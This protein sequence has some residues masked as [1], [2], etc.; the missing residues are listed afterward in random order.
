MTYS[1]S[2]VS[3]GVAKKRAAMWLMPVAAR[4]HTWWRR[5]ESNSGPKQSPDRCL[6]AQSL[7]NL[8]RALSSDKHRASQ[9]VRS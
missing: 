5:G 3:H 8:G 7:V 1:V 9:L 6:Q 4:G 2:Y